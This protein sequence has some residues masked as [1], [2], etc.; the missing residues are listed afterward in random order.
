MPAFESVPVKVPDAE[1]I[2][3]SFTAWRSTR[4][5]KQN[6]WLKTTIRT[7]NWTGDPML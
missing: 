6:N 4:G 7:R 5:R 3:P 2:K 1:L